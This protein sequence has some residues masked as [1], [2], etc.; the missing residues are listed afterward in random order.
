M[1]RLG[2]I[3]AALLLAACAELPLLEGGSVD[4]IVSE[5]LQGARASP[6]EQK[7]ALARAEQRF[8]GDPSAGSR[9]RLATLLAV[10]PPPL[11]DDVRAAELLAPIADPGSPGFGRFAAL[12]SAQLAERQRLAKELERAQ[13]EAERAGR[14]R[15]RVEHERA[16][17]DKERDKREEVLRQQLEALRAIE[18]N[19]LEREDRMRKKRR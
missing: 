5:A 11:R 18:R 2:A 1:K 17:A 19:I 12:L 6:P 14:E 10:L 13:R 8:N 7:A 16:A 9:L 15:E 4:A 3:L